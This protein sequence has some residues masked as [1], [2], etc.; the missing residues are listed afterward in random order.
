MSRVTLVEPHLRAEAEDS[1]P[2]QL[3]GI[4]S[5]LDLG[6]QRMGQ[7]ELALKDNT[8]ITRDIRD[9]VTATRVATKVIRWLGALA[10]A[11]SALY[12]A[13]YQ[14]THDGKLP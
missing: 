13:I 5:R 10:L 9:A 12:A 11:C 6:D 14:A 2:G 4:R 8:E 1:V 3:D 7:I